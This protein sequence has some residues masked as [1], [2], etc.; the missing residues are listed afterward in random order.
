MALS[1]FLPFRA[2]L[3]QPLQRRNGDGQKLDDVEALIYGWMERANTVACESAPPDM[4]EH[5]ERGVA[6]AGEILAEHGNVT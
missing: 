4:R 5:A 1:F 6:H 2:F 3:L